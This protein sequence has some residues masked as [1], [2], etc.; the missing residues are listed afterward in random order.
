MDNNLVLD[1]DEIARIAKELQ[2]Q[3]NGGEPNDE[4]LAKMLG[5]MNDL[6]HIANAALDKTQELARS[7]GWEGIRQD[8]LLAFQFDTEAGPER[9]Y[10]K[11]WGSDSEG[12]PVLQFA[13]DSIATPEN[14]EMATG[15]AYYL[16]D[17]NGEL[18]TARWVMERIEGKTYF[19]LIS[20]TSAS[21]LDVAG[22]RAAIMGLIIERN[23]VK[24]G[25][26]GK[27]GA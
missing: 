22:L 5:K 23:Q 11:Y 25:A 18:R 2:H 7:Q 8:N 4:H 12:H 19:T 6:V 16:M 9:I 17:R 26:F 3:Y 13:S 1:E 10:I 14:L 20:T 27:A 21:T 15:F 24:A